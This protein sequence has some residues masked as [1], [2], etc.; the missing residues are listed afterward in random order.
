MNLSAKL[1]FLEQFPL[2][3]SLNSPEKEALSQMVELKT[4]PRYSYVYLHG[5]ISDRIYFLI[6][7][8]VKIGC[9]SSDGKEVIKT[10]LHPLAMSGELGVVGEPSRRDF[11]RVMGSEAQF[12]V[13]K[14]EDFKRLMRSNHDM[15]TKVLNLVG[16]RLRSAEDRLESLIFKDARTRIV[17][18][19]R[20]AANRRGRQV[21]FETLIKH[22][23]TQ[24]DI[25]NITG[26]SRQTVTSVLNELKKNNQIHF[27]RRSI[28]VRDLQ[29]LA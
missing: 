17:D 2:F 22:S 5:D 13:L 15:T 16:T 6:K 4:K 1:T 28:L 11:A 29:T 21:G 25:A 20:D 19:I 9:H 7:G 24:Q 3:S 12:F 27:T 23:L 26:T 8:T 18:F 10:V 14:V